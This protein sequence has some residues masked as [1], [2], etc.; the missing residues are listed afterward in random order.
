M[1]IITN[2]THNSNEKQAI[3]LAHN[4]S[5]NQV[6]SSTH[7]LSENQDTSSHNL[8]DKQ[9]P[10]AKDPPVKFDWKRDD[11]IWPTLYNYWKWRIQVSNLRSLVNSSPGREAADG[12]VNTTALIAALLLTVP[13]SVVGNFGYD[14]FNWLEEQLSL[15]EEAI[16]L[17]SLPGGASPSRVRK[18]LKNW[19]ITTMIPSIFVIFTCMLYYISRP[20]DDSKFEHWWHRGKYVVFF[21]VIGNILSAYGIWFT[22]ELSFHFFMMPNDEV[23]NSAGDNFFPVAGIHRLFCYSLCNH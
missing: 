21:Q 5:E 2:P 14:Y 15:C 7:N 22:L 18:W 4:S 12:A 23:C 9:D 3:N 20:F 19:L 1:E 11:P 10:G 17:A 8:S 16:T 13:F 6:I